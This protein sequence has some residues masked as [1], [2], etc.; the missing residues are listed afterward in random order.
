MLAAKRESQPARK[1]GHVVKPL[2][3]YM[4]GDGKW[5]DTISMTLTLKPICEVFG[6]DLIGEPHWKMTPQF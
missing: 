5:H 2:Y 1:N 6:G 4:A 3:S